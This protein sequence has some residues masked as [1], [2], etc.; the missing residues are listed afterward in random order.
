VRKG[1]D[2]LTQLLDAP[3]LYVGS[4]ADFGSWD[5]GDRSVARIEVKRLPGRSAVSLDYESIAPQNPRQHTEHTVLGRGAS[6]L[7]LVV[8]HS[9]ADTVAV[10]H[11]AESGRFVDRDHT[12]S[13]PVEIR[14]QTPSPGKLVY[15]WWYAEPGG[16]IVQRDSAQVELV[17]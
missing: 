12:S 15:E 4:V 17:D 7:I 1:K 10:L 16:T 11:E 14:I 8:A 9:H 13:F 5:P 2:L 6:G 3:G